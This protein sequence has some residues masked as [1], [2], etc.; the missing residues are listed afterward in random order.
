MGATA[1]VSYKLGDEALEG[2]VQPTSNPMEQFIIAPKEGEKPGDGAES[3][4]K[5]VPVNIQQVSKETRE[6][7]KEQKKLPKGKNNSASADQTEE[8][9]EAETDTEKKS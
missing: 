9:S 3:A 7:I 6:Y 4:G 2:V 1:F 8:K 5:F